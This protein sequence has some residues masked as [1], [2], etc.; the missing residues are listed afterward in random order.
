MRCV[1]SDG[2]ERLYRRL[3]PMSIPTRTTA[4]FLTRNVGNIESTSN[5]FP[6][7]TKM[8]EIDQT[9]VR[10]IEDAQHPVPGEHQ[11]NRHW[12]RLRQMYRGT[13]EVNQKLG[14]SMELKRMTNGNPNNGIWM[15]RMAEGGIEGAA[16][17]RTFARS[18][19]I[20]CKLTISDVPLFHPSSSP[21]RVGQG[22]IKIIRTIVNAPNHMQTTSQ[23][24]VSSTYYNQLQLGKDHYA[25]NDG[26]C[27]GA[28]KRVPKRQ[29]SS[30][31]HQRARLITAITAAGGTWDALSSWW[32]RQEV[33]NALSQR[34][35]PRG[36]D[37]SA[38][39]EE[40][41]FL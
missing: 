14:M 20:Q 25:R 10:E 32:Q 30:N 17:P 13:A 5:R 16:R 6:V 8:D 26:S 34:P 35:E 7:E 33:I 11:H 29:C 15:V 38:E 12:L 18:S 21:P 22:L 27:V 28:P 40:G 41:V 3:V 31:K 2:S 23:A 9:A 19:E 4:N 1:D 37:S 36:Y 39:V 24:E